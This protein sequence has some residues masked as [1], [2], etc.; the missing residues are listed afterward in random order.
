M[1]LLTAPQVWAEYNA[2]Q[3]DLSVKLLSESER[4]KTFSYV[5]DKAS[6]GDIVVQIDVYNPS[7]NSNKVLLLIGEYEKAVQK[8]VIADLVKRGYVVCVPDYSGIADGTATS[9]PPSREYGYYAK[10]GDHIKKVC[11]TALDTSQYLYAVNIRRA[12]SFIISHLD[13]KEIITVGFGLGVEVAIQAAAED[14]RPIALACINGAS[15]LEYVRHNKYGTDKEMAIDD[16]LMSWLTGVSSIAYAK[17]LN[18]PVLFA[19]GSNGTKSDIDRLS[20]IYNLLPHD[21]VRIVISP[22]YIDN[23]DNRAYNTVVAWLESHFVYSTLPNLPTLTVNVNKEGAIYADIKLDSI[24]KVEEVKVYFS[25][26]DYNHATRYWEEVPG[27]SVG[28]DSYIAK[29]EVSE[30]DVPLFAFAEIRYKNNLT[31]TSIPFYQ[32]LSNHKV[33]SSRYKLTPI[34]F[35]HST[36]EGEFT[37]I[38]ENAVLLT[39]S[40]VESAIP[41][42]LKGLKCENGGMVCFAIG[43]KKNISKDKILQVDTYS[44]EDEYELSVTLIT[45]GETS[46]E[47]TAVREIEVDAETFVSERFVANDFKDEKFRPLDDWSLVKGI[48]INNPGIIVGKIM[49]I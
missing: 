9:F 19:V 46:H 6:D 33:K 30:A 28:I 8:E 5:A 17:H 48:R 7:Y 24:I 43:T 38:S 2:E 40:L 41:I 21:D 42:G 36:E 45:G 27:E 23:I 37:E 31:L 25:Y 1:Q 49:Y 35:Q 4:R 29:L 44:D 11:P 39:S 12:I 13:K 10:A 32:N 47:Y 14:K 15:Y 20:N 16:E 3:Y 18:M 34:V 22:G 26:G